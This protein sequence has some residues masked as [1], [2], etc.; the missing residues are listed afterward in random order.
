ML[1]GYC[2]GPVPGGEVT[3][4]DYNHVVCFF[5]VAGLTHFWC[6]LCMRRLELPVACLHRGPCYNDFGLWDFALSLEHTGDWEK[7]VEHLLREMDPNKM[8]QDETPLQAAAAK[9]DVAAMRLLLLD[10][11]IRK[12]AGECREGS[13]LIFFRKETGTNHVMRRWTSRTAKT[14]RP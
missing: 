7:S 10:E 4:Y 1:C 5:W 2:I 14:R 13:S 3:N 8:Y 11:R 12:E 9:G 6:I